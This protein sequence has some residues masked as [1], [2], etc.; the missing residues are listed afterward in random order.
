MKSLI[1]KGG[2]GN[3]LFQ[4]ATFY[5]L[6][7]NYFLKDIKLD[8]S[9]GF[10]LDFKYKRKLEI[11]ED[12]NMYYCSFIH[13]KLNLILLILNKFFPALIKILPVII[14]NDG[15]FEKFIRSSGFQ[16]KYLIFNGYFQ[17]SKIVNNQL[18]NIKTMADKF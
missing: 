4:L 18:H 17:N 6:K 3:Q 2:L 8:L 15:N 9:S 5:M 14:I 12:N 1:L 10:N 7:E 13:E 11:F 16:N